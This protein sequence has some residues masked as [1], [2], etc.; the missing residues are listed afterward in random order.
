[1]TLCQHVLPLIGRREFVLSLGEVLRSVMIFFEKSCSVEVARALL[2]ELPSLLSHDGNERIKEGFL[3]KALVC[4]PWDSVEIEKK[5]W[6]DRQRALLEKA[7]F[8]T[9]VR[10]IASGK[11]GLSPPPEVCLR[12]NTAQVS[13]RQ[14]EENPRGVSSL[15]FWN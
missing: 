1:M 8:G 7:L 12:G 11:L 9:L 10:N 13:F 3:K 2:K 14:G 4:I 6:N 15:M 5:E